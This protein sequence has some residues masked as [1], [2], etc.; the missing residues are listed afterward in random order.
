MIVVELDVIDFVVVWRCRQEDECG[1]ASVSF[2]N[3]RHAGNCIVLYSDAH[4]CWTTHSRTSLS[5]DGLGGYLG[6]VAGGACAKYLVPGGRVVA[7]LM[8]YVAASQEHNPFARCA[9]VN[10]MPAPVIVI[11]VAVRVGILETFDRVEKGN[12]VLVLVGSR[13]RDCELASCQCHE[14][15]V[16]DDELG[17]VLFVLFGMLFMLC[18]LLLVGV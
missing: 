11:R 16:L 6:L 4:S 7:F 18:L 15:E 12:K 8:V 14:R 3:G 13:C 17:D 1:N 10:A 5:Q 9:I 2:G